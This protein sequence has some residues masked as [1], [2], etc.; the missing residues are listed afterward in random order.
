MKQKHA[1]H[2]PFLIVILAVLLIFAVLALAETNLSTLWNAGSV[3]LFDTDNVTISGSADFYADGTLFKRIEGKYEQDGTTSLLKTLFHTPLHDGTERE[4]GYTVFGQGDMAYSHDIGDPYYC[5]WGTVP[6]SSVLRQPELKEAVQLA[7]TMLSNIADTLYASHVT[8]E[9]TSDGF[10][11]TV[12]FEKGS[13][14][15]P[16]QS[17]FYRLMSSFSWACGYGAPGLLLDDAENEGPNVYCADY[18]KLYANLYEEEFGEKLPEDYWLSMMNAREGDPIFI[19]D[20]TVMLRITEIDETAFAQADPYGYIDENGIY[21][22]Y[23]DLKS[24][25]LATGLKETVY[26]NDMATFAAYFANRSGIQL[27]E[28]LTDSILSA[29]D[30]DLTYAFWQY[31][32]D[33]NQMYLNIA[34]ADENAIGIHIFKDGKYELLYTPSDI[35]AAG[36]HLT[37]FERIYWLMKEM[38]ID[39]IDIT[40]ET[41]TDGQLTAVRGAM[42]MDVTLGDDTNSSVSASFDCQITDRGTTNLKQTDITV[43]DVPD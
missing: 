40:L 27:T 26:D 6:S 7:G 39:S 16:L 34:A 25:I 19:R 38:R 42:T 20:Q 15:D 23:P 8:K 12:R 4:S 30:P 3:L 31:H 28:E 21:T 35:A 37:P 41:D 11:Y 22:G 10:S 33:M 24:F 2:R 1:V 14:P 9:S 13:V 29:E 36:N 5:E 17:L 43:L 32:D 18:D